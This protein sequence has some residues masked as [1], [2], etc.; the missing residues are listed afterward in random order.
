MAASR[1][2]SFSC[3]MLM[4]LKITFQQWW[5]L[6][7]QM[8]PRSSMILN[9]KATWPCKVPHSNLDW[10]PFLTEDEDGKYA[11][12][13]QIGK[14]R[15]SQTEGGFGLQSLTVRGHWYRGGFWNA[16]FGIFHPFQTEVQFLHPQ[17]CK[18][19]QQRFNMMSR[20][21]TESTRAREWGAFWPDK[22]SLS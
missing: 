17:L 2:N 15:L 16:K 7:M 14:Q 3:C 12:N 18:Q 4:I 1:V 13:L 10:L 5:L 21:N 19:S 11:F 9:G 20:W 6:S 8:T 22:H